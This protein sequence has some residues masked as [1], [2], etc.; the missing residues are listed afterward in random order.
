MG[1]VS[2][3]I[4]VASGFA[5]LQS[6]TLAV[7]GMVSLL[8]FYRRIC[9]PS[10]A[11]YLKE[12]EVRRVASSLVFTPLYSHPLPTSI[13]DYAASYPIFHSIPWPRHQLWGQSY[14]VL[15][16]GKETSKS[17]STFRIS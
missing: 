13:P 6:T 5:V 8:Y 1:I 12:G 7:L 11:K 15:V 4:E 3:A 17:D 10:Y 16:R 14:P 9:G 2:N